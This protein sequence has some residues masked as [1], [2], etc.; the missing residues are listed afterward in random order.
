MIK[1]F[2]SNKAIGFIL[3]PLLAAIIWGEQILSET[4][5]S[6]PDGFA[7]YPFYVRIV[8]FIGPGSILFTMIALGIII[9][10][11]FMLSRLNTTFFFIP[12][13]TQLPAVLYVIFASC[14]SDFQTLTPPLIASFIFIFM[15]FKIMKT[16][17]H[18]GFS[19][20]IL[21]ASILMSLT[22]LIYPPFIFYVIFIWA[23]LIILRPFI[24]REWMFTIIGVI[25]PYLFKYAI[26][27]LLDIEINLRDD[28]SFMTQQKTSFNMVNN[29]GGYLLLGYLAFLIFIASFYMIRIF[30]M[31]KIQSRRFFIMFLWLFV[32]SILFMAFLPFMSLELIPIISISFSY[33]IANLFLNLKKGWVAEVLFILLLFFTFYYQYSSAG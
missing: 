15:L 6:M 32:I 28:F 17:E 22:S 30:T 31:K 3:L 20:K 29:L 10:N 2:K 26:W 12:S 27:Y 9:F 5:L 24:W 18:P 13:R 23:A 4:S 19:I 21:D 14:I 7:I 25:L 11:A 1:L 16:Y 8:D 33:L